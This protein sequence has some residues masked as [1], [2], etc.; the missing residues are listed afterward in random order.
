[1]PND[2]NPYCRVCGLLQP[3]LPWGEDDKTPS[4]DICDCCGSEFGY[5]D[6]TPTGVLRARNAWI[7]KGCPWFEESKRPPDWDME[8]QLRHAQHL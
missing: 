5:H 6:S 8:E 1:M 3:G 4:W 7:A 2:G